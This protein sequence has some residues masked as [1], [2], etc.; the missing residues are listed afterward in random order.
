MAPRLP[1]LLAVI[2][3]LFLTPP[4][5]A[6]N[7]QRLEPE[8]IAT[9]EAL[10]TA[11][12]PALAAKK[13]DG[14]AILLTWEALYE[15]LS[16]E[17]RA[18]LDQFRALKAEGLGATSHYFGEAGAPSDIVP[19]GPQ[20]TLKHGELT[21]LDPQYLP[22]EVFDAY[23][24]MMDAMHA[25]LGKRLLVESG[26]RAPAYQLYLFLFYLPKHG[27]SVT[28]TNRFVALPG[29]SEHGYPPRQAI[30]FI[31]EEGINGEDHPEEFE[32]L[33][34]YQW[35]QQHAAEFGF[36]LSYPRG[37]ATNT[38]F[39][40]WHWHYESSDKQQATRSTPTP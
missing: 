39:E 33:P 20:H 23:Q 21:P 8:E 25:A 13:Q 16:S 36:F 5:F 3:G 35:L 15:P 11:L 29:Y 10:L 40:P 24:R 38:A 31:N 37:N 1:L 22:R 26:Y 17:P 18:F 28:E 4:A 6:L 2:A 19:V 34:E 27:H 30:D 7:V 32:A 14:S 12:E 9:L